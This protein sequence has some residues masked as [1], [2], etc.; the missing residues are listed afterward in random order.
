MPNKKPICFCEKNWERL[1]HTSI[2]PSNNLK[3]YVYP[4]RFETENSLVT[5]K[6]LLLHA[7]AGYQL[8]RFGLR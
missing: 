7:Q 4:A 5:M 3:K 8:Y 1:R 6:N 2:Q